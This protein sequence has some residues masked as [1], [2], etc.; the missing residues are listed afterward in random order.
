M[1]SRRAA[2]FSNYFLLV[3][4]LGILAPYLQ[5]FLKARGFSPAR[6]GVLLAALFLCYAAV[7]LGGVLILAG[8]GKRILPPVAARAG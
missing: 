8:F 4:S 3:V 1:P 6:I 7:P 5:L 2:F